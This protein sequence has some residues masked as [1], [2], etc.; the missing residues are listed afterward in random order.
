MAL[1]FCAIDTP[2]E[3]ATACFFLACKVEETPKKL[4]D[5][6]I[7]CHECY[8]NP[9][10]RD[11]NYRPLLLDSPEFPKLR[12][13]VLQCERLILQT[14]SFDLTIEQP[15]K[16]FKSA[17]NALSLGGDKSMGQMTLNF[18]NDRYFNSIGSSNS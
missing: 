6:I 14:L 10:R 4:K 8:Y 5:I 15:H 16:T 9:N 13:K 12:Q 7:K 3:T 1:L 11:P 18:I 17:L 2:Q